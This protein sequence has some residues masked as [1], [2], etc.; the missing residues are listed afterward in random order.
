MR[1]EKAA[2]REFTE[3]ERELFYCYSEKQINI[4]EEYEKDILRHKSSFFRIM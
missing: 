3:E 1:V 4:W 2:S